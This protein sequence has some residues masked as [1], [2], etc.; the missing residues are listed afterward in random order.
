MLIKHSNE[1]EWEDYEYDSLKNAISDGEELMKEEPKMYKG[2]SVELI[3]C[4]DE[5]LDIDE[6]VDFQSDYFDE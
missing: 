2:F 4:L 6:V 3:Y 5:D 1:Y